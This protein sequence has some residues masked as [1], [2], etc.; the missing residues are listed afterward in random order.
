LLAAEVNN[1][2]IVKINVLTVRFGIC[3]AYFFV[4]NS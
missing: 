2:L 1:L 4:F 3:S